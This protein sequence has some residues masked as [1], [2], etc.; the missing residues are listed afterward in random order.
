MKLKELEIEGQ[1]YEVDV[2]ERTGQFTIYA[3]A[4]GEEPE[5]YRRICSSAKLEDAEA[6]AKRRL[7]GRRVHVS[8]PFIDIRSG[9][10]GEAYSVH[11]G[12]GNVMALFDGERGNYHGGAGIGCHVMDPDMPEKE[13]ERYREII[14][15]KNVLEE[16]RREIERT[17][18]FDLKKRVWEALR[19]AN[20]TGELERS[21]AM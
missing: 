12:N 19:A 18:S 17:H 16:E 1:T 6:D 10:A 7:K 11:A 4:E 5:H 2:S 13:L 14:A 3:P 15:Q 21:L 8:V 9:L 20:E